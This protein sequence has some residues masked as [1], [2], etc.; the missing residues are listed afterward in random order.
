MSQWV[1]RH[2][3][4]PWL[5]VDTTI[6][7]HSCAATTAGVA[8]CG[9][10][11]L[12]VF[13]GAACDDPHAAVTRAR[14][15]DNLGDVTLCAP[16]QAWAASD[17]AGDDGDD[18]VHAAA[19]RL[20]AAVEHALAQDDFADEA[21]ARALYEQASAPDLTYLGS[22]RGEVHAMAQSHACSPDETVFA[23]VGVSATHI[24]VTVRL[25]LF[26]ERIKLLEVMQQVQPSDGMFLGTSF[27]ASSRLGRLVARLRDVTWLLACGVVSTAASVEPSTSARAGPVCVRDSEAPLRGTIARARVTRAR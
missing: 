12:R 14:V 15:L 13:Q 6:A 17:T 23:L 8:R 1:A 26:P 24:A 3:L 2:V 19:T 5:G 9:L 16:R 10:R 25:R 7:P 18:P 4:L 27:P 22:T 21:A 11:V 20:V